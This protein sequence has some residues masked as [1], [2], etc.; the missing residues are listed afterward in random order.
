[1]NENVDLKQLNIYQRMLKAT[2]EIQTVAKNLCVEV[3]KTSS[4]KAVGELEILNA[5]KP[6]EERYGIY[7]YPVSRSIAESGVMETVQ[8]FTDKNGV[9]T[10]SVRKQNYMR[11]EVVYRFVNTDNPDEYLDITTYGDGIDSG[12]KAPG[13]AMTYADKYALM[14]AYKIGTGDD[15]D[16]NASEQ[17]KDKQSTQ[18]VEKATPK[19]VEMLAKTYTGENLEKLLKANDITKLEDMPKQKATELIGKIMENNKKG[20]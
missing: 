17:L 14:K 6:I 18:N 13:K 2:A 16:Q 12:D 19:Q 3:T 7:S 10:E 8:K 5:V 11:L 15:P 4:Y 1:M 20:K 9:V